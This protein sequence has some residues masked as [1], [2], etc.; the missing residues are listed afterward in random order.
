M[1]DG[2]ADPFSGGLRMISVGGAITREDKGRLF[3]KFI[4]MDGPFSSDLLVA[5][6]SYRMSEKWVG[7]LS[8]TYDFGPTGR[9]GERFG[10]T[11]IGES[12]LI[13]IGFYAD[14]GRNN[15]GARFSI[16]PRFLPHNSLS[17]LAG[18]QIPPLG[19][20]GLE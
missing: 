15:V 6:I 17:R 2:Y 11:R 3:T 10:L 14:H 9:I 12:L 18:L 20:E 4:S 1:S 13:R 19:S 8:G 16:E 7:D 5:A